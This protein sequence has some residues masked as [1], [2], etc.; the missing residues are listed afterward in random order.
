MEFDDLD[1]QKPHNPWRDCETVA[2]IGPKGEFIYRHFSRD[3][4]QIVEIGNVPIRNYQGQAFIARDFVRGGWVLYEDLCKG[5]VEGVEADMAK[6]TLWLRVISERAKG[7]RIQS[8]SVDDKVYLHAEVLRRREIG[9]V[10]SATDDQ[11]KQ[12]AI[13]AGIPVDADLDLDLAA[14][15]KK[16]KK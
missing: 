14:E 3:P 10:H 8:R 2:A 7:T 6:W 4:S 1:R 12:W 9:G 16:G 15:P 13:D 5:K 11:V